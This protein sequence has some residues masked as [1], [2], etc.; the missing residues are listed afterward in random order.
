MTRGARSYPH[1]SQEATHTL[2][3]YL[4]T[5]LSEIDP[6]ELWGE[7]AAEYDVHNFSLPQE[8]RVE[9]ARERVLSTLAAHV[10]RSRPPSGAAPV[11]Q[12]WRRVHTRESHLFHVI[13]AGFDH[14]D[15]T[16]CG[17][18]LNKSPQSPSKWYLPLEDLNAK[19]ERVWS[20][21]T[22]KRIGTLRQCGKCS[23]ALHRYL[24]DR[25]HEAEG[26]A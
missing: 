2:W 4:R 9:K 22:L 20:S 26:A 13:P 7:L 5:F 25:P 15:Q 3:V 16:I 24:K 6:K 23:I 11:P 19:G 14:L 8:N 17:L 1:T 21:S 18:T 10:V 12:G